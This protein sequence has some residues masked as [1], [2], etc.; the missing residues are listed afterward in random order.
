MTGFASTAMAPLESAQSDPL[1]QCVVCGCEH[2]EPTC[3]MPASP[4]D[5]PFDLVRCHQCGLVE[6]W[7][8]YTPAELKSLYT[9]DYYVF[10]E[11]ATLRWARA[12]QQYTVH[13]RPLEPGKGRRL[14]DVGCALGHLAALCQGRG[15]RVVGLDLSA[16][17]VSRA[18]ANFDIHVRAGSLSQFRE[19]LP[20]FDVVMLGDV[21]EHVPEPRVFLREVR[22]VLA[23]DGVV[24]I[25]T[26]NWGSWW[27]RLGRSHWLGLNRYHIN[28]FDA[29]SL[30]G[31]LMACGFR[32]IRT[33]SYTHSR[34]AS[35]ANRPEVQRIVGMLPDVIAWRV[36]RFLARCRFP[37]MW[38]PLRDNPPSSLS[39][40]LKLTGAF[41]KTSSSLQLA[42]LRADNLVAFARRS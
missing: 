20:P 10:S 1:F 32:D 5:R 41:M 35:W 7:P 30:T 8:R 29:N 38:K 19:T 3:V 36:N 14:L 6:Q 27:R 9:G 37:T 4:A 25:D 34:Y 11:E 15:W 13:L 39:E 40:A 18:A 16:E 21:L 42:G 26:P 17:A 24:C 31:L 33:G 23:P 12:V 2:P 28:I 22:E